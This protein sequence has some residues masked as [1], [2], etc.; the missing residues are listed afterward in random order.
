MKAFLAA[1]PDEAVSGKAQ[2]E[3]NAILSSVA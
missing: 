1:S 3:I 2:N